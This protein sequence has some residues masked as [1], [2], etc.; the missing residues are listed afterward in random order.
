MRIGSS[1]LVDLSLD[2]PSVID[3][4]RGQLAGGQVKSGRVLGEAGPGR[5]QV[6]L[7]GLRLTFMPS[8]PLEIGARFTARMLSGQLVMDFPEMSGGPGE[9]SPADSSRITVRTFPD[10]LGELGLPADPKLAATLRGL[11]L[12]GV[13]LNAET[14]QLF[15][16][17]AA[18]QDP[19]QAPLLAF[20]IQR[21]I[22]VDASLLM[23][24]ESLFQERRNLSQSLP[25][26]M[27]KLRAL[28]ENLPDRDSLAALKALL[29]RLEGAIARAGTPSSPQMWKAVL[30]QAVAKSGI[31]REAR[32]ALVEGG[33]QPLEDLKSLLL[34]LKEWLGVS[35][36]DLA[37][38]DRDQSALKQLTQAALDRIEQSQLGCV[39]APWQNRQLWVIQIPFWLE[40]R[41][42]FIHLWV[43]KE[44]GEK[45]QGR[46]GS[47]KA[48]LYLDLTRLGALHVALTLQKG[49]IDG[50]FYSCDQAVVDLLNSEVPGWIEQRNLEG[51][52]GIHFSS[53]QAYLTDQP[54]D[55]EPP[56]LIPVSP[57][58]GGWPCRVDV[59]A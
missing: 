1:L 4:L 47:L 52:E 12:A 32:L 51:K 20:L 21:A 17:H 48:D 41:M 23:A 5:Y 49:Q 22:P 26:L 9:T 24:V 19:A 10:L 28:S 58:A 2:R 42:E 3:Q 13:S 35:A 8:R 53:F 29:V 46:E 43:E 25:D 14:L 50:R 37:G 55:L 11:L 38:G 40:N 56:V 45:K 6:L 16:T 15:Q 34:E 27:A 39:R 7:G 33:S 31:F 59:E 30:E 18:L 57:D 36:K 44:T 54:E